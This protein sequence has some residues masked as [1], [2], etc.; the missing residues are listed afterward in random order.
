M[1]AT[2]KTTLLASLLAFTTAPMAADEHAGHAMHDH[3]AM[4]TQ[5]N[6]AQA[7]GT[8]H[9]LD[10]AA[11]T[12]NLTHAPIPALGWPEMTMDLPVTK[13]VDLAAFKPGDAVT[14]TLKKGRDNR[15][16]ITAMEAAGGGDHS[17]MGH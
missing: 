13:R 14:F 2:L 17:H 10:A 15:F 9:A 12:I 1:N 7:S 4:T 11:R 6:Q 3:G 16:R 5:A 8:L